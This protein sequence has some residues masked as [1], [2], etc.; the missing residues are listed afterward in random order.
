MK[1]FIG[2]ILGVFLA[3]GALLT[4]LKAFFIVYHAALIKPGVA[5]FF[6]ILWHGLPME[7]SVAGYL[8]AFP[9]LLAIV[10]IW[11]KGVWSNIAASIYF[12]VTSMI[13][14][15]ITVADIGLYQSWGFRIDMTPVFY[16]RTSPS[17]ALASM[18]PWMWLAGGVAFI[19]ISLVGW[20]LLYRMVW[21][22]PV[23]LSSTK[24]KGV[25]T[26][27]GLILG[28]L[29]VIP[30]RGGVSVSTMNPGVV[31]YSSNP[32]HNQA[33]LNPLFNL[34]YSATHQANFGKQFR[35]M[36]PA[37]ADRVLAEWSQTEATD[38]IPLAVSTSR[39]DIYLIILESFSNHL[40]PSLGGEPVAVRL[41]S[42]ARQGVSFSQF[43]GSSFRTDRALTAIL[44]GFPGQP[45]TSVMKFADKAARLPSLARELKKMGYTA[46]YYYGGD[47]NFT[48][49]NAYLRNGGYDNI[50]SDR[51]F[52]MSKRLSKWGV[53]DHELLKEVLELQKNKKT[54]QFNVIQTSSSHEPFEVPYSN[55]KFAA[56]P[57]QNAFAYTD[58]YVGAFIDSLKRSPRW[59]NSLV[60]LT[61]DH[62]GAWPEN[63]ERTL[64]HHI[65]L[66]L[67]GGALQGAPQR[68][69]RITSQT[70]LAGILLDMV[71]GKSDEFKFSSRQLGTSPRPYAFFSQ[72]HFAGV[73]TPDG[74][75]TMDL[76]TGATQPAT[77]QP[78]ATKP[79]TTQPGATQAATT[80]RVKRLIQA[81]LQT[82][83]G[84]LDT[85]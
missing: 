59:K 19:I 17:A 1:Q 2:K 84:R 47:I 31:Y 53:H 83:H 66:I 18:E 36:D 9:L 56:N 29:L 73:V 23:P 37:E 50:L 67:T 70:D 22:R 14:A 26:V 76:E 28:G 64:R 30:I 55:P 43:Y 15:F 10:A 57:R 42:I 32:Q 33:A 7:L 77:T 6:S 8:T 69:D 75:Y 4:A 49:M 68:V 48:N 16:L 40:L 78:S 45:T 24:Q 54:P 11:L 85:L 63:D 41:D 62:Q 82:L 38:S 12:A 81:Y 34:L 80:E 21:R 25:A 35:Y 58:H 74:V 44:S 79:A 60:V 3:W 65:P 20:F 46:N 5:D 27:I 61:A 39:P 13:V 51:D 71:G 52:P 72:P